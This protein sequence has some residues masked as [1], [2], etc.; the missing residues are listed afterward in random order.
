VQFIVSITVIELTYEH[1]QQGVLVM[2]GE[3]PDAYQTA[4]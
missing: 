3:Y 4:A 2:V 1:Q